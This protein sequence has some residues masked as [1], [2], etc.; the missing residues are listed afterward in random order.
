MTS[1]MVDLANDMCF[2][3]GMPLN[4]YNSVNINAYFDGK[5]SLG[6]H[7]DDEILFGKDIINIASLSLGAPRVFGLKN[8]STGA[9]TKTWLS[10]GD[11]ATMEQF[12]QLFYKHKV[13]PYKQSKGIRFNLTFRRIELHCPQCPIFIAKH[14]RGDGD[15]DDDGAG[16]GDDDATGGRLSFF[17]TTSS[18]RV[19]SR[20]RQPP[21][22]GDPS[23]SYVAHSPS[24][25]SSS[26]TTPHVSGISEP[27]SSVIGA[28]SPS[29]VPIVRYSSISAVE[30]EIHGTTGETQHPVVE[31]V[32]P[33]LSE[34]P[35]FRWPP[36]FLMNVKYNLPF[37]RPAR[38]P[39]TSTTKILFANFN[40]LGPKALGYLLSETKMSFY[41]GF[42]GLE[43]HKVQGQI[44]DV[45]SNLEQHAYRVSLT[46]AEPTHSSGT[47]GGEIVATKAHL[48]S[49]RVPCDVIEHIG[50]VTGSPARFSAMY[51]RLKKLTVVLVAAYFWCS[52]GLSDDNFK[53]IRQ[54]HL[55]QTILQLPLIICGDFNIDINDLL[56]SGWLGIPDLIPVWPREVTTTLYNASGRIISYVLVSKCIY[57]IIGAVTPVWDTPWRPHLSFCLEILDRPLSL[58]A[59]FLLKPK[60]LPIEEANVVEKSNKT[61]HNM[62]IWEHSQQQARTQLAKAKVKSGIAIL[63]KPSSPLNEDPKYQGKYRVD[64]IQSGEALAFSTLA[65]EYYVLWLAGVPQ[66]EHHKYTGRCQY[67]RIVRKPITAPTIKSNRFLSPDLDAVYS[68]ANRIDAIVNN[69]GDIKAHQL[70]IINNFLSARDV[71]PL[72]IRE[73]LDDL[74]NVYDLPFFL[75]ASIDSLRPLQ[76]LFA[77][78]VGSLFDCKLAELNKE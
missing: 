38:D 47:H 44:L 36:D 7:T 25:S 50:R 75:T 58:H 4:Y 13:F 22:H 66:K 57:S 32:S 42:C 56:N 31:Q 17:R 64:S 20:S 71:L 43:T 29:C 19:R 12:T 24:V 49:R 67:P 30:D 3:L 61:T 62:Q 21:A 52:V 55:L 6:W 9:F 60:P 11:V 18:G 40:S 37:K 68:V 34:C 70:C 8:I 45:K 63:G 51:I 33:G 69:V 15:G 41:Q 39:S 73:P 35:F 1:W 16:R 72:D 28:S 78:A 2:I 5:Q 27:Y 10:S 48:S 54:L 14:T 26:S 59:N 53:I 65:S 76:E 77:H 74:V 23:Q 46:P